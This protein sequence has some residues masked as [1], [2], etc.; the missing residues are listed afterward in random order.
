MSLTTCN[1]KNSYY[2]S[3]IIALSTFLVHIVSTNIRILPFDKDLVPNYNMCLVEMIKR[4]ILQFKKLINFTY[5][6]MH[7][8]PE[9]FK[10]NFLAAVRLGTYV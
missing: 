4:E 9:M 7:T 1:H 10:G 2:F 3:T 5:T 6:T 8:L